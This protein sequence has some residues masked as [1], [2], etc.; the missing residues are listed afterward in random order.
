M[1]G[2]LEGLRVLDLTRLLPGAYATSLLGD[3]GADVI[4]VERPGEGDPM[5]T[6]Q[7][8]LAGTSAFS[9]IV[10]RN[11]RSIALDLRAPDGAAAVRR[12]ARTSDAVLESF[13][14]GVADRLGLGYDALSLEHPALVYCSISGYGA[15]GPLRGEPGHD[16]NYLG[17]AGVLSVT[18]ADGRPAIPGVQI[19]DLAG[20]ALLGLVGLLAALLRARETGVGD[21][22][23]VS[24]TDG[25]F[26]L[27]SIHLGA[28]FADGRL[29]GPATELLN[30][31]VP[32][33]GVY[34]CSDGRFL[35]VGALELPFWKAL[36]AGVGRPDLI[37]TQM[38][39]AAVDLWRSVFLSRTR[40]EWLERLEGL[41]ACVGPVN[42]FAEAMVD[43][44]LVHRE[45]VTSVDGSPQLGTPVKLRHRPASVRTTA[46][47]LGE[48]SA[49]VL[50]ELGYTAA[51]IGELIA[52]GVVEVPAVGS[53]PPL[54]VE[55]VAAAPAP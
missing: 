35:T 5:R 41:D 46:P 45:M 26:S 2:P 39:T 3:L 20:G 36:C 12:L 18:G 48:H 40:S 55:D 49:Q 33:Y 51:E 17:R 21:R 7:P 15:D 42:D 25:A 54:V 53:S 38:A 27:L 37:A 52:R 9:W 44:Q 50:G 28:Y 6:Y 11:K 34:E 22:V 47:R 31:G 14:P 29:P 8:R 30:G 13:R 43:E 23:D 1:S 19:G 24:M 4:K 16:V 32:C 10:D